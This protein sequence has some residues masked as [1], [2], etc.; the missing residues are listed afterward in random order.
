M[1]NDAAVSQA[2][3]DQCK[4]RHNILIVSQS[5]FEP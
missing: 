2:V 4:A 3:Y 5:L 1:W